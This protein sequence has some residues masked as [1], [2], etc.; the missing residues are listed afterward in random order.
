MMTSSGI[1]GANLASTSP[2]NMG[3]QNRALGC[4]NILI[5]TKW[6][7]Y[8]PQDLECQELLSFGRS[9]IS[10]LTKWGPYAPQDLKC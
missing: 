5:L 6:G 10:I 3:V 4:S 2:R 7:P 9:N 8:M 1:T